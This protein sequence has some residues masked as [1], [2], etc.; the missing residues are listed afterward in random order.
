MGVT[1]AQGPW[2]EG[3]IGMRLTATFGPEEAAASGVPLVAAMAHEQS[4]DTRMSGWLREHP[5]IRGGTGGGGAADPVAARTGATGRT[6][7]GRV[8]GAWRVRRDAARIYLA[9]P[10]PPRPVA[11]VRPA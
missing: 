7:R 10:G 6:A 8:A 9:G 11:V 2:R 1:V 4:L 5:D 3:A